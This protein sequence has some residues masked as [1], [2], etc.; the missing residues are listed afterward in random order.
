MKSLKHSSWLPYKHLNAVIKNVEK[1]KFS[2]WLTI[3]LRKKW[4]IFESLLYRLTEKQSVKL[5]V[6]GK[7]TCLSLPK[8]SQLNKESNLIVGTGSK[9]DKEYHRDIINENEV[10]ERVNAID[11]DSS[12]SKESFLEDFRTF[13]KSFLAE[14]NVLKKQLLTSHTTNKVNKSNN[15][16]RLIILLEENFAF[17]KEQVSKKDKVISF[18]LNQLSKQNN[19]APHNKTSNTIS[20]QT[21][22]IAYSKSTESSKKTKK[23]NTERF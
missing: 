21:E 13:K 6:L 4:K 12:K 1:M 8:E 14:V 5:S 9:E 23:S 17:L 10:T 15:S 22:L 2:N 16:D 7:R 11:N 20:I 19:P 3:H 18:L